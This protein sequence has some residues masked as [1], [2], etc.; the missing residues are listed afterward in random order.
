[1]SGTVAAAFAGIDVAFAK[2]KRLPIVVCRWRDGRLIPEPLAHLPF[3][4]P[5]GR[6]NAATCDPEAVAAFA[7]ETV[8]YLRR[9]E[10]DLGVRIVRIGIDAPSA[11]R[12]DGTSRRAA[13]AALDRAGISC[14]TTPGETD[15]ERI[16]EKVRQ[17]LE[18]GGG[19]AN[20]PHANQLWMQV[21]FAL[22][23]ELG[24]VAECVEVYPQATIRQL[25]AGSIHKFKTGGVE[26]QLA[27]VARHTGWPRG[28]T[29]DPDLDEIAFGPRHDRLDAYLSAW[30]AALDEADRVAFGTPPDDVIWVPRVTRSH[31]HEEHLGGSECDAAMP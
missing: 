2:T 18:A 16:R 15:F 25:G 24:K 8:E 28:R 1:M 13:E 4:P 14:F 19:H 20:L 26:S 27:A 10:A 5:R 21:G 23:R 9:V 29:G 11:P 17:H 3:T 30:V 7:A 22:F 12:R 31:F 6:G